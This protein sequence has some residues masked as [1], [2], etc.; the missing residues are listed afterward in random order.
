MNRG[1]EIPRIERF[2]AIVGDRLP[3]GA[4]VLEIGAGDG[5]LAEQ[6][7]QRYDVVAIDRKQR[8]K[9][10][11]IEVAFEDYEAVPASFDAVVAQLVLHHVDDIDAVLEKMSRL[12][13]PGGFVAI[14][15]YGWERSDDAAFRSDRADLH[16]SKTML[17]ALRARFDEA[18]YGDHAYFDEGRGDDRLGFTFV[19]SPK[20]ARSS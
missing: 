12:L 2:A 13:R 14:D 7:A 5:L 11:V 16:T 18:L 17:A 15:D 6:L 8:G 4:T 20:P 19:G 1:D 9:Y 10:R 3:A